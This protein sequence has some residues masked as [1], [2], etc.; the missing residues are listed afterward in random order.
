VS[1]F[2][3]A[4]QKGEKYAVNQTINMNTSNVKLAQRILRFG[5]SALKSY[6]PSGLKRF[7]W[8]NEY[9]THKWDFADNTKSDCVYAHL[10]K[11][12]ANG[13]ILDLGCGTGNTS[14]ELAETAYQKYLG[15]DISEICLGKA[16]K[17]SQET[18]RSAKNQF[19]CGD[20]IRFCTPERFDVILFRESLYHVPM[21]KITSTLKAYAT[22]LKANGVFVV[23]IKTL[24]DKDG[25][26]K[27]RPIA[28]LRL[29]EKEFDVIENRHYQGFGATVI[30][31]RPKLVS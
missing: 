19:V 23:R 21:D 20:F 16:R 5:Q 15:V 27:P 28:M 2:R 22:N 29:L 31:F 13:S 14:N 3:D 25:T 10:E 9:S 6:G 7:L 17:R 8:D 12:A 26:L 30:V 18:G 11:H 24:D 1:E 4:Y